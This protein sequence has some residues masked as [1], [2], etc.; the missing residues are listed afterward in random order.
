MGV[1]IDGDTIIVGAQGHPDISNP[2]SAYVFGRDVGG[3]GAWG[4]VMKL[5]ASDAAAE[6]FFGYSVAIC[7]PDPARKRVGESPRGSLR[8]M[9]FLRTLPA[10][11]GTNAGS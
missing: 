2:G 5:T 11:S 1:A 7:N 9:F 8:R 6:D 3:L 10:G 4:Q